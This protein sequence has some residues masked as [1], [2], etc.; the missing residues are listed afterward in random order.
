MESFQ[1]RA[2]TWVAAAC[3]VAVVATVAE[4]VSGLGYRWGWWSFRLGFAVLRYAAFAGAIAAGLA[5]VGLVLARRGAGEATVALALVALA[6][7]AGLFVWPWHLVRV[8]RLVPP[9]HDITTDTGRPPAFSAIVP[10]RAGAANGLEYGGEAVAAQQ[11]R[12]YPDI[13]PLVLPV[14]PEEAFQKALA[15]A[16][17]LG[18]TI[19]ATD[20]RAGRIEAWDRTLWYG[21]TDDVVVRIA[22]QDGGSRIDVRSVS[23][24]GTSDVGAN[25]RRIRRFLA[26]V[27]A[28]G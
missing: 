15:A 4:P 14:A 6:L 12:A 25:A 19:V 20:A 7:G 26:A 16:R 28:A 27:R 5:L 10:L 11:R 13:Q 3:L 1:G 18:W 2:W 23:R 17:S 24:V 21:F 22:P 9:I 8:A